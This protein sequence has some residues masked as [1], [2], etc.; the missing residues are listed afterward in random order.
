VKR[1][2]VMTWGNRV[3][4]R[5]GTVAALVLTV[6]HTRYDLLSATLKRLTETNA[7]FRRKAKKLELKYG[8]KSSWKVVEETWGRKG[9]WHPHINMFVELP[10]DMSAPA[11]REFLEEFVTLWT[12]SSGAT[13]HA[14]SRNAQTF[15][16]LPSKESWMVACKYVFKHAMYSPQKPT[17]EI[18]EHLKPWTILDQ[19]IAFG[20]MW[21][22]L[23]REYEEA[24]QGTHRV[25]M[26]GGR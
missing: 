9:G 13:D 4:G 1:D 25:T 18:D 8:V 21:I 24:L 12:E 26:Y 11:S 14:I 15:R 20:G 3:Y 7:R 5:G 22:A 2:A 6:P 19:A 17:I 10:R 16:I 23:W